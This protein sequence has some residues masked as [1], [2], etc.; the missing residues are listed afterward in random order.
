MPVDSVKSG[1]SAET[2][3]A[4]R[5]YRQPIVWFGALVFAALVAGI[6]TTIVIAARY[7]DEPLPVDSSRVLSTPLDRAPDRPEPPQ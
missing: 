6:A 2:S 3:A 1:S 4:V 7:A 5:W